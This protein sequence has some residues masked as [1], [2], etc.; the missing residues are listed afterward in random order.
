M[1]EN[2][3]KVKNFHMEFNRHLRFKDEIDPF[4]INPDGYRDVVS[5]GK[6]ISYRME[7]EDGTIIEGEQND[8]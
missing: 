5:L 6:T 3:I 4:Y 8:R 7:F 2:T 1:S